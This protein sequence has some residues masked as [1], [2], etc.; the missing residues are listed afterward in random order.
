MKL[1]I[2]VGVALLV[3]ASSPSA[4]SVADGELRRDGNQ[5]QAWNAVT[6]QWLSV[7]AFWRAYADRRGGLSWGEGR[8]YPPYRQVKEFDTFLV[9][10][11]QGLCLMEFFHSRWRRANDVRR[12]DDGMNDHAGCPYVFD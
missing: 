4:Q 10:T 12:W 9:E 6:E 1:Q 2:V 11:D 8:E 3:A 7:E 5:L